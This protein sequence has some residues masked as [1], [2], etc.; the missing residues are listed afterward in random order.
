MSTWSPAGG[1]V[2]VV[3][4]VEPHWRLVTESDH[5]ALEPAILPAP[6]GC[7][8]PDWP[9]CSCCLCSSKAAMLSESRWTESPGMGAR[10]NLGLLE[11]LLSGHFLRTTFSDVAT[12]IS[13]WHTCPA[14]SMTSVPVALSLL[15]FPVSNSLRPS[16]WCSDNYGSLCCHN[17]CIFQFYRNVNIRLDSF[18]IWLP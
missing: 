5:E 12:V 16:P 8:Q 18:L 13:M 7:T 6:W 3:V 14:T 2:W 9:G 11:L 4:V 10:A 1:A 17:I 15:S